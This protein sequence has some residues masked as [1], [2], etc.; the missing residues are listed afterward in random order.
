LT[1]P[2]SKTLEEVVPEQYLA[3]FHLH[4]LIGQKWKSSFGK[5]QKTI[6]RLDRLMHGHKKYLSAKFDALKD[7]IEK[8]KRDGAKFTKCFFCDFPAAKVDDRAEPLV[9]HNCL[10]CRMNYNYLVVSCPSCGSDIQV[11]D[12]GI[13]ECEEC[14]Y[15]TDLE[16][17]IA[18]LG[19]YEDPKEDPIRAYCAI[20]E[21]T[22]ERTV[23]PF[24]GDYLCLNCLEILD[25]PEN[26]DW[27][28]ELVAG[29]NMENSYF[30]GCVLCDGCGD[31]D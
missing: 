31:R 18:E 4:Y 22:S 10:V 25:A 14:G 12:M 6:E 15:K 9:S 26:C 29:M 2:D 8:E 13:G 27:C 24:D 17:L 30:K 19:P 3:W 5:H 16:F 21:Y 7:G 23:I 20:C 1:K 28:N 11:K